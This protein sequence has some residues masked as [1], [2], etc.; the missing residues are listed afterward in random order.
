VDEYNVWAAPLEAAFLRVLGDD[1][2]AEL[3]SD[4][5]AVY[6]VEAPFQVDYK[7]LL[8]VLQ[9]DGVLGDSVSLR[10]RW[11]VM[12]SGAAVTVKTFNN[13]QAV[14]EGD[15]SYDALVAAHSVAIGELIQ[16]ITA[17]LLRLNRAGTP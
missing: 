4:H 5:V 3:G 1:I 6:P 8:D 13:T 12:Q 7:V 9:F 2:A 10:V 16:V 17:E 11:V 15:K 14:A